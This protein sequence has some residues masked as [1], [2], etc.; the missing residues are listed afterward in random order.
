[1]TSYLVG[2]RDDPIVPD[3]TGVYVEAG[4]YN[5]YPYYE[6]E[7]GGWAIWMYV[8]AGKFGNTYGWFI[9]DALGSI[10]NPS[11]APSELNNPPN[12]ITNNHFGVNGATG[13]ATV[14]E[15]VPPVSD[16]RLSGVLKLLITHVNGL[17]LNPSKRF[18]LEFDA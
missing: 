18:E 14:A 10:A 3:A 1:M 12:P 11:F 9:S 15:Y 17:E 8:V 7:P 6:R 2:S 4:T 13:T 5:G 16:P